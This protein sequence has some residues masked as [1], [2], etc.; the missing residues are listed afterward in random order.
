VF[1][2]AQL[3]GDANLA[4]AIRQVIPHLSWGGSYQGS[5]PGADVAQKMVWGE[6][7]GR[8][9]L[10]TS[11]VTRLGCFLLSPGMVYPVHG[12]E[13]LEIYTVVSGT[14]TVVH[15]LDHPASTLIEAPGYSVTPEGEAHALH[16][17]SEPVLIVYCW[18][19]DL[20]SPVWWWER[21]P[22]GAW[23]KLFPPIIRK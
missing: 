4:A 11:D 17:G 15:G 8:S 13:A 21:G 9:G 2:V 1:E 22:D 5:G 16:V 19:G 10:I 18:T 14:M 6:V 20:A 12:H 7:V 3:R 23:A